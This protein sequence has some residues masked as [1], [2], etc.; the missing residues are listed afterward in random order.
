[1][2]MD[3]HYSKKGINYLFP[4]FQDMNELIVKLFLKEK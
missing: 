1:M 2:T 3:F 4:A